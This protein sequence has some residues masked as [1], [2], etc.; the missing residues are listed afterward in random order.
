MSLLWGNRSCC[1]SWTPTEVAHPIFCLWKIRQRRLRRK[2]TGVA[3]KG[4]LHP[5]L[6]S[7]CKTVKW[8]TCY[9]KLSVDLHLQTWQS[10]QTH[11]QKTRLSMPRTFAHCWKQNTPWWLYLKMHSEVKSSFKGFLKNHQDRLSVV[12]RSVK[13]SC[14]S[15]STKRRWNNQGCSFVH[16][17]NHF[18]TD[19]S[20]D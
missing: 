8:K 2:I 10:L 16:V 9:R 6:V 19:S 20:L 14:L 15:S 18:K 13:R 5:V 1:N 11:L 7:R 3:F 12:F 17:A 4:P